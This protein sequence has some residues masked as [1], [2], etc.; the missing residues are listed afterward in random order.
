[1]ILVGSDERSIVVNPSTVR[2]EDDEVVGQRLK[3][4]LG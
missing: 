4:L 1:M 2:P 3:E